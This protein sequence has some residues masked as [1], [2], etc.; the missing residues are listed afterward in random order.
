MNSTLMVRMKKS[1][2]FKKKSL[3]GNQSNKGSTLLD[4]L[5]LG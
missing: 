5:F 2:T 1:L 3:L 4:V